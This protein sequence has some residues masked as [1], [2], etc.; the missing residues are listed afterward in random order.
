ML[1]EHRLYQID[2]L[3]RVYKFSENEVKIAFDEN[4]F[5]NNKDPKLNIALNSLD[6][7]IDPNDASYEELLR[8]PGIGPKSAYRIVNYRKKNN[9]HKREQLL[10]LGVGVKKAT[11][12]L[13]INGGEYTK[14]DRWIECKNQ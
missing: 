12:F 9:I 7:P 11:P 10:N 14:I 3:Y 5:L 13:K 4:G 8:V 2:W 6:K 1:R